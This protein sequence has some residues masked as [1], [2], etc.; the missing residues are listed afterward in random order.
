[1]KKNQMIVFGIII[2]IVLLAGICIGIFIKNLPI[3]EFEPKVSVIEILSF[4]ATVTIGVIFPFLIKKWVDDNQTI[5]HYLVQ[6]IEQLISEIK[7]NKELISKSFSDGEFN[8]EH[9]DK[10]NFT[11]HSSELQIGSIQEQFEVSFPDAIQVVEEMKEAF[12]TYKDFLTGGE[13]MISTFNKIELPFYRKHLN[14]YN[15]FESHLKRMIHKV[16]R[17]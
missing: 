7:E 12:R 15:K 11:F 3:I 6:E 2:F 8:S 16:Y 4:L 13:M 10:I 17:I 1:M 14:E 5:K 9:R